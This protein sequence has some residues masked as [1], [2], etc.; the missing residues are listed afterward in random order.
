[1]KV[2]FGSDSGMYWWISSP[3]Q[4]REFVTELPDELVDAW[5]EATRALYK[6]EEKI[7]EYV[8][9]TENSVSWWFE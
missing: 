1:M 3:P 2:S 5:M 9:S 4:E 8:C 7:V 6:A